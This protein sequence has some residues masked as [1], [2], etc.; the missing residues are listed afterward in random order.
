M[1]FHLCLNFCPGPCHLAGF[2]ALL[3]FFVFFAVY[4]LLST[5]VIKTTVKRNSEREKGVFYLTTSGHTPSVREVG[6]GTQGRNMEPEQG[7]S[8][9]RKL[10]TGMLSLLSYTHQGGLP[11]DGK[12]SRRPGLPSPIINQSNTC[13]PTPDLSIGQSDRSI[14]SSGI[15]LGLCVNLTKTIQC[16]PVILLPRTMSLYPNQVPAPVSPPLGSLP[17]LT[18]GH[19]NYTVHRFS[20]PSCPHLVPLQGH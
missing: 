19:V 3:A 5:V 4:N 11:K 8:H 14:P 15:C 6:A 2:P 18:L 16:I 20:S 17:C 7:R 13:P 10:F 1:G 12:A 9:G